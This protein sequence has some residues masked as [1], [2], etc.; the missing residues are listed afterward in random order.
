MPAKTSFRTEPDCSSS[1][2]TL[3]QVI[4]L[5]VALTIHV[6]TVPLALLSM[7]R[8]RRLNFRRSK[9]MKLISASLFM[10]A[11]VVRGQGTFVYDQQ[12]A[13]ESHYLEGSVGL[14]QQP[15]GQSFTPVF[16][17]VGFIRIYLYDGVGGGNGGGS[18]SINLY[19]ASITGPIIGS[20][21]TITL[22]S[23]FSGP[24]DFL[25]PTPVSVSPGT[26]YY[27]QPMVQSGSAGWGTSVASGY[28]YAGGNAFANGVSDPNT[29]F[30]FREG[31]VVP[32]PGAWALLLVGCGVL[33][34]RR[35]K[36]L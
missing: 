4:L 19:A 30:W 11:L 18:L 26:F 35:R 5:Y 8:L 34:W 15:L 25:F 6:L 16:S 14:G 12:S 3:Q 32:E 21:A 31:I 20:A 36:Y 9:S 2:G 17:S 28:N 13:D 27:F 29:D 33:A 10:T 24:V 23:Q 7:S 22:A 1:T